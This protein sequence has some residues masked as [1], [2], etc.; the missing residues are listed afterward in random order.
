LNDTPRRKPG[1]PLPRVSMPKPSSVLAGRLREAIL[2]G[3]IPE[4]QLLPSE[5]DLMEQTGLTRGAV[6]DALRTLAAEGLVHTRIGRFGG[7]VATL[8]G[9]DSMA[10]AI[11]R[12]VK[13][14]RLPLRAIQET[15]EV[16]E[17]FLA[18][19]AASRRTEADIRELKTLQAE[20][21]ASVDDFQKF[22]AGNIKWHQAVARA[23][24]NDLLSAVLYALSDGIYAATVAEEY[25]TQETRQQVI[26]I[27]GRINDA[28]KKGDAALAERS[29]RQHMTAAHSRPLTMKGTD[30]QRADPKA[31]GP[32]KARRIR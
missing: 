30:L 12:F 1:V 8:P 11:D 17:P 18:H 27:H 29:M 19:C 2:H 22:A 3:E 23:S 5:R 26:R 14:R 9:N 24:G 15:R 31:A 13:G 10:A 20:L 32:A 28:I 16:L 21:E 25:D 6:R 4:G 7:S